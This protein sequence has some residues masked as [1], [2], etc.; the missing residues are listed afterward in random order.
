MV[1]DHDRPSGQGR[2]GS[3]TFHRRVDPSTS[4]P[5]PSLC[6]PLPVAAV[7]ALSS[8]STYYIGIVISK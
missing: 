2:F 7:F 5:F 8:Q 6:V 4:D 1:H 3:A